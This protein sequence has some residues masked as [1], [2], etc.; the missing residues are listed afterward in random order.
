MWFND[1]ISD[2]TKSRSDERKSRRVDLLSR[3]FLRQYVVKGL[4][5]ITFMLFTQLLSSALFKSID[6]LSM[7]C[8]GHSRLRSFA[9]FTIC[10]FSRL[11]STKSFF[12]FFV[13]WQLETT[14]WKFLHVTQYR[15]VM[16]Q[17][18]SDVTENSNKDD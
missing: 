1:E 10:Q 13:L 11:F 18:V 7:F 14:T 6:F 4:K 2:N 5:S 17:P 8:F 12:F 9:I 3:F 16:I 15:H